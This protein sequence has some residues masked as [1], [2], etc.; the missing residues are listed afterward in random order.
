SQDDPAV[1]QVIRSYRR[2]TGTEPVVTG[3]PYSCDLALY[4]DP[5]YMP[6]LLL[7]PRGH[8]VHAPDEWVIL[9]DIDTLTGI[10][11]EL[12]AAWCGTDTAEGGENH[13]NYSVGSGMPPGRY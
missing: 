12:A 2:Y 10:Y 5:G 11:A 4:G 8:N 9:E 13:G 7:G 1:Q 6:R 3:A